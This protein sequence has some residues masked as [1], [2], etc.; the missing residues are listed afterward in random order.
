MLPFAPRKPKPGSVYVKFDA[1]SLDRERVLGR[2]KL[3]EKVSLVAFLSVLG[4]LGEAREAAPRRF[5]SYS[6]GFQSRG[7]FKNF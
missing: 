5:Y 1:V 4:S 6:S 2:L 7:A 3:P